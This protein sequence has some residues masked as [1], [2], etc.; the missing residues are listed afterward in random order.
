[1]LDEYDIPILAKNS[2]SRN[3]HAVHAS[4]FALAKADQD[5]ILIVGAY[6]ANSGIINLANSLG[7]EYIIANL[8]FVLSHELKKRVNAPSDRIL[9]TEVMPDAS[10]TNSQVVGEF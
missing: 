6:P 4:L 9:V 3:T 7:H 1:M 8:S 2:F 10:D 5:A